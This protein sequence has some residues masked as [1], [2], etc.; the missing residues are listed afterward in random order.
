M[1][2]REGERVKAG[3]RKRRQTDSTDQERE[4]RTAGE[5]RDERLRESQEE[6]KKCFL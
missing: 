2:E 6:K 4:A 1:R 5:A 3:E